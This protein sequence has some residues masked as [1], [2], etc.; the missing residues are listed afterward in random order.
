MI[1]L[2]ILYTFCVRSFRPKYL[3]TSGDVQ[4][5]IKWVW[6]NHINLMS[7]PVFDKWKNRRLNMSNK[8]QF[9]SLRILPSR[10]W[11]AKTADL[12]QLINVWLATTLM[13][14]MFAT[15]KFHLDQ[16]DK[17]MGS[18]QCVI[19]L[20]VCIWQTWRITWGLAWVSSRK[21][22]SL[23]ADSLWCFA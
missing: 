3:K 16:L 22:K 23:V 6:G 4:K 10:G 8:Q 12:S 13:K 7:H 15:T 11:K 1:C 9:L 17:T 5:F 20:I 14:N 21:A 18:N 19:K 2:I